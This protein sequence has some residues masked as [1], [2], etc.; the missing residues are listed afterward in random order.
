MGVW[1]IGTG[2]ITIKPQVDEALIKEYVQFSKSCF[3][4]DYWDEVFPNAW[5]FDENNKLC[6]IAGKFAEPSIWYQHIKENFF[7]PRGYEL[8]GEMTIIGECEPGFEEA[9]EKSREKYQQWKMR[10]KEK[11]G[12]IFM[13]E[14]T[15]IIQ[16]KTDTLKDVYKDALRRNILQSTVL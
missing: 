7:E 10:I 15:A 3:P 16:E 12:G 14:I 2:N 4:K 8:K 5:F 6:S 11:K 1:M 13:N 9:C